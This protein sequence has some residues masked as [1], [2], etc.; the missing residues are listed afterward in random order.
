MTIV[1]GETSKSD[2]AQERDLLAQMVEQAPSIMAFVREP[3]HRIMMANKAF[4]QLFGEGIIDRT[5]REVLPPQ[6]AR[7]AVE[8]LD[9]VYQSAT[10]LAFSAIEVP[11]SRPDQADSEV[12]VLDLRLQPITDEK[13]TSIGVLG[14]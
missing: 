9:K 3:S 10:A 2:R 7:A 11:I 12:R 1:P 8:K 6:I 4:R 13:G 5:A 14:V